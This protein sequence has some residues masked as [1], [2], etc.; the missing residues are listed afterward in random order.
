MLLKLRKNV[1]QMR[2]TVF[3]NVAPERVIPDFL[4]DRKSPYFR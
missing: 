1:G 4:E 2:D 3:V